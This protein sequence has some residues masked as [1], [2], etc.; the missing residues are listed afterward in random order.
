MTMEYYLAQNGQQ[1]GPFS[2][3]QIKEKLSDGSIR[4]TDMIW[5]AGQADWLPIHQFPALLTSPPPMPRASAPAS[6]AVTQKSMYEAFIGPEKSGYYVPLFERFDAGGSKISWNWPAAFITQWWMLYRGMF[7]WGFLGYPLL[8][9]LGFMLLGMLI[10]LS[11]AEPMM[12]IGA[13]YLIG[14]PTAFVLTGLYSNKIYHGH[15]SKLIDK[16]GKLGL[17]DQLRR[18]WL[19]RKGSTSYIWIIFIFVGIAV[20]GILAAIAIPAYQDYV[21]RAKVA[22]GLQEVEPL[23]IAY[24]DYINQK[25]ALPSSLADLGM[26]DGAN[27]HSKMISSISVGPEHELRITFDLPGRYGKTLLLLPNQQGA[28]LL[29]QC[30]VDDLPNRYAPPKCRQTQ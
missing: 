20:I 8:S 13:I 28:R 2:L 24:A 7:L 23:K 11:G 14:I 10:G 6:G 27:M 3:D 19:I 12:S 4:S 21:T 22:Q 17:S 25:Q 18:E 16:S 29:W 1:L 26:Q 9:G 15:V 30:R 5:T